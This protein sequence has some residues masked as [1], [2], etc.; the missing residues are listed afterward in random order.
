MMR[1]AEYLPAVV[2]VLVSAAVG[3]AASLF[4]GRLGPKRRVSAQSAQGQAFE[5]GS[6][7]VGQAHAPLALRLYPML[8]A[9]LVFDVAVALLLPWALLL[10]QLP[11]QTA[12]ICS[13]SAPCLSNGQLLGTGATFGVTL[14]IAWLHVRA[15]R[16][17]KW[18]A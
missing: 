3:A 8:L 18:N 6:D 17:S 7:V 10:G 4:A 2:A 12:E 11:L 13:V 16:A 9:F 1:T 5:G 15:T 14:V